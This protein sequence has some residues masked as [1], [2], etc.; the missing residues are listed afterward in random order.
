MKCFSDYWK[1]ALRVSILLAMSLPTYGG[2]KLDY[3]HD[4]SWP[5]NLN[6]YQWGVSA[7]EKPS[8]SNSVTGVGVDRKNGLVY[9]LVRTTPNVRVFR[10]DGAFVHAWSP[11]KVG[12]VHMLHIDESGNPWIADYLDHTVTQ[13][14]PT[15]KVLLTLGVSGKSGMDGT[16]F[17]MPTD[18]TTTKDFVF[19][20][21]GYGNNR[22]TKFDRSGNYISMWGD[23]KAGTDDGQFILPHSITSL[24]EK[25]YVADRSGG[26]IQVFNLDG[27]FLDAWENII[28]PW[29]LASFNHH[30]Y[31]AGQKFGSGPYPTAQSVIDHVLDTG[32]YTPAPV[33]Q[34]L[35]I[36][37]ADGD[38]VEEI[39]LPQGQDFGQVDW[40]HGVDVGSDGSVYFADV[41]G[42]HIQKW[43]RQ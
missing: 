38:I 12:S 27:K 22:V 26:R 24:N 31:V 40:V 16:H 20:S 29:G 39:P 9:V 28:A 37:S 4:A 30:I 34:D 43:K 10:E 17:N 41:M 11:E 19:V 6:Q 23:S 35:I 8:T 3:Q 42:N 14:A 33:G 36:F 1:T 18:V 13:Y 7:T 32:A 21:D 2:S 25:I 15:G 5:K